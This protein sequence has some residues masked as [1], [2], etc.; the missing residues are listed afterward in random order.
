MDPGSS[1]LDLDTLS[2]D[3]LNLWS[4]D[5]PPNA[6]D[7]LHNIAFESPMDLAFVIGNEGGDETASSFTLPDGVDVGQGVYYLSETSFTSIRYQMPSTP[8]T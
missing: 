4:Q 5:G 1:L 3:C 2:D 6:L 8:P 7:Y